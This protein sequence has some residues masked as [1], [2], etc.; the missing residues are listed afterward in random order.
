MNRN[1][2]RLKVVTWNINSVRRRIDLVLDYLERYTPDILCL[3]EI[4]AL[5]DQFPFDAIREAGWPYIQVAG[6]KAYNGVA[7]ICR[8]PILNSGIVRWCGRDDGRHVWT[9]HSDNIELHNVYVPAGGDIPDPEVN[10]KF[11]HK[12]DFL[13]EMTGW[14]SDMTPSPTRR[15][16][17]GDLNI[18]PLENDVW[19][20]KKLLKVV[21]HTP[22][23][24]ESMSELQSSLNWVDA[25][26]HFVP[27]DQK[28]YSWWSYRAR[29]WS[30]SDYGRR[31]DHIWVTPDLVD[32]LVSAEVHREVRGWDIASDHCPVCVT[33]AV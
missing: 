24:V 32:S 20:H 4:K 12:L 18:A 10:D 11:R 27:E 16:I 28:L 22:V 1:S 31:L 2:S 23:E 14:F 25:V 6:F 13:S 9:S 19:S 3:Q 17:V 8:Q 15:I 5:E 7:T 33:I 29:D 26:R 30:A 21:S